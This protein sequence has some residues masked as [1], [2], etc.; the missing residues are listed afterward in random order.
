MKHK[1]KVNVSVFNDSRELS[2]KVIDYLFPEETLNKIKGT[3]VEKYNL[4]NRH[5]SMT[6]AFFQSVL[7][8]EVFFPLFQRLERPIPYTADLDSIFEFTSS[9]DRYHE[10]KSI[11]DRAIGKVEK[12]E[13]IVKKPKFT[14]NLISLALQSTK[15]R[16]EMEK[17]K[18]NASSNPNPNVLRGDY[19]NYDPKDFM[20]ERSLYDGATLNNQDKYK[21]YSQL[22]WE[23]VQAD[24]KKGKK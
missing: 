22:L 2:L 13:V 3:Q 15:W 20:D 19:I 7:W 4:K 14:M 24:A 11:L 17:P 5:D 8:D 9:M 23:K 10:V 16:E 12:K 1:L 6:T 21:T 18:A